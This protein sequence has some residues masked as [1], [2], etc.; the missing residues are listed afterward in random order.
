MTKKILIVD[1]ESHIRFLLEQTLEDFE[2]FDVEIEAVENGQ[3]ALD[4][5]A[6][7][8][9]HLMFLDVM[10]PLVNGF[11]VCKNVKGNPDTK[12]IFVIL[13]T[14]K[15]QETDRIRGEEVGA[16]MYLTKPFDPDH[17]VEIAEKQLGIRL[18]RL[19]TTFY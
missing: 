7:E 8:K 18:T 1:D 11:E 10:M 9:P 3:L 17:V 14:A 19:E 15:G 12:D 2:D 5:I 6:D 16:D 13:L 4:S